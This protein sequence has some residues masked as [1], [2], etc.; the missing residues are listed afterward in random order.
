M[1]S[2]SEDVD[3]IIYS[4]IDINNFGYTWREEGVVFDIDYKS[5]YTIND[6]NKLRSSII[7]SIREETINN[8]L[9]E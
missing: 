3:D 6:L 1:T 8:I 2:W 4:E 5:D 7:S 9:Q